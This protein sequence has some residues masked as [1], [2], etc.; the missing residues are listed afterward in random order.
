MPAVASPNPLLTPDQAAEYLGIKRQTLAVW[1]SSRRYALPYIL[2][3]RLVKYRQSDLDA[4][5]TS[6]TVGAV[7]VEK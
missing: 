4:F 2:C 6:R 7:D 3:G 5:L 1:R